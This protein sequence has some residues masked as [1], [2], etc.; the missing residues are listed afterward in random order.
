MGDYRPGQI[1]HLRTTDDGTPICPHCG[2]AT[3]TDDNGQTWECPDWAVMRSAIA[4]DLAAAFD[5]EARS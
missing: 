2:Q 5:R 4:R 3:V 1:V